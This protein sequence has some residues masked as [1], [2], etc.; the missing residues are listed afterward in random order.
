MNPIQRLLAVATLLALMLQAAPAQQQ[1]A[2]R[3]AAARIAS[4]ILLGGQSMNYATELSD[5]F[6]GR[7]TGTTA[8]QRSAEWAAAKFRAA[9]I[10]DVKMEAFKIPNG[11]DRGWARARMVAPMARPLHI[12][13]LGWSPSTPPGGVRGEVMLVSDTAPDKI[14][15]QAAQIKG[16][17]VMV[18]TVAVFSDGLAGFTRLLAAVPLIKEAGAQAIVMTDFESNNVL[19]A[20]GLTWGAQTSPLPVAQVGLEDAKLIMRLIEKGPVSVEF[21][22][23]NRTS[24][25]VEVNNVVAEIRG[26]EK[27]D[28]WII[29]GAHLD[30]WDY[31]TGAQDNGTGCAMVLEAARAIAALGVQPRR[32]IRFALWGGEEQ[33]LLGSAAY[34]KAHAAELNNCVAVL[35]TDNGAGHPMGWKV[36]GRTDLSEALKPI[37]Q[38]LLKG[39][40]GDQLS[41]TLTYDTD[42]GPFMLQGIPALDLWVDMKTY[43]PVHHKTS[44]TVDKID[45]HNLAAGSAIV[46][47]TAYAIAERP[48]PIAPH[49]DHAAVEALLNKAKLVDFLKSIEAWK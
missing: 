15:A 49:L 2:S 11:W 39:L 12:E 48:D 1:D 3:E 13:S 43:E 19:N 38:S 25:P 44:D 24:G 42:H 16:R 35:N 5:T 17:V 47:M 20:F 4:S 41:Q 40:S 33:G 36:Q 34:V 32:S 18:N 27:P 22:F 45:A 21:Q 7:L 26:R 9:G 29:I 14:R 46:A 23:D 28:E 10:R 6:G 37:S 30:S 31:G 8:Y